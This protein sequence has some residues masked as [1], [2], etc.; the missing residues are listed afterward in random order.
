VIQAVKVG[1]AKSSVVED[2]GD[3]HDQDFVTTET[4]D[5]LAAKAPERVKLNKRLTFKNSLVFV[6]LNVHVSNER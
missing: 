2:V 1:R 6:F 4:I 5:Q 3:D